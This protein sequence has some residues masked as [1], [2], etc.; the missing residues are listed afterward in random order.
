MKLYKKYI[1]TFMILV[2]G[3]LSGCGGNSPIYHI[4]PDVD[5]SFFKNV[6]VLPLDNLTNDKAAGEIV[7]QLVISEL[8]ASGLVDVV[9]PGEVMSSISELGI[10]NISSLNKSQIK[11]LGN[12]LNV[13]AV[14]IGSVDQ[15]GDVKLGNLSAPEVT[16]TLMMADVESGNI[17]WS[18]TL[19]RGGLDFM[20]RHFGAS[21]ETMSEIVQGVV[22]E[23]I[24]TLFEY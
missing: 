9:I 19:T 6:A 12:A 8:L 4:S 22:R 20:A 21:S 14:I 24:Q 1:L 16:I 18:I 5:F 7:K 15:Y 3:M 13:E 11:A 10:Q 23:A 2:T 17:I